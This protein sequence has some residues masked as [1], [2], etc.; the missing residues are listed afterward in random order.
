MNHSCD[1]NAGAYVRTRVDWIYTD[2]QFYTIENSIR[3]FQESYSVVNVNI[4]YV[5][6]G[7]KWELMLGVKNLTDEEY[8]T[9]SRTQA[10]SSSVFGSIARP[11]E[12]YVQARYRFGN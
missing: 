6:S 7:D 10:D 1:I 4:T 8:F 12:V 9:T 2:D 5:S 11:R 3:N